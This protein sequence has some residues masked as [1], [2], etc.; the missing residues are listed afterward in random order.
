MVDRNVYDKVTKLYLSVKEI[1]Q[2]FFSLLQKKPFLKQIEALQG[3]Q[4]DR[5]MDRGLCNISQTTLSRRAFEMIKQ[6]FLY[7][8]DLKCVNDTV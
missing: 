7:W 1:I 2:V 5:L 4:Y 8:N 6:I 3:R